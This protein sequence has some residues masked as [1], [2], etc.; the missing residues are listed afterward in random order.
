MLKNEKSFKIVLIDNN[1]K[2]NLILY[3]K[4]SFL[5]KLYLHLFITLVTILYKLILLYSCLN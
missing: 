1:V 4:N 3:N 5:A 2:N